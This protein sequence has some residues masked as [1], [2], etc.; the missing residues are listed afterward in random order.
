MPPKGVCREERLESQR[1]IRSPRI[2]REELGKKMGF[3]CQSDA[4]SLGEIKESSGLRPD[5]SLAQ[6][7]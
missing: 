7:Q 5:L 1:H 2:C 6:E 4:K 3:Y